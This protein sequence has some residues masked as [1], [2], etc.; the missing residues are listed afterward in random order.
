MC[1]YSENLN[2]SKNELFQFA[3]K[4]VNYYDFT[5]NFDENIDAHTCWRWLLNQ[6]GY[7]YYVNQGGQANALKEFEYFHKAALLGMPIA[8]SNLGNCYWYGRGTEEDHKEA[9]YWHIK[10]KE[11]GK[12][13]EEECCREGR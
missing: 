11:A 7:F 13:N 5:D 10:S 6:V 9:L 8:M 3:Y 12:E 1:C 2:I 4:V